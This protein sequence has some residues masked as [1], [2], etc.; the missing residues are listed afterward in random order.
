MERRRDFDAVAATWDENPVRVQRAH[1]LAEAMRRLVPLRPDM[2][3]MDYGCGTGLVALALQPYVGV[4]VAADNA[5]GMLAELTGKLQAAGLS[6]VAAQQV[7][8]EREAWTGEPFDVIVS[9]MALHHIRAAALVVKR[10]AG[11]LRPGGW[12]AIADLAG[13]SDSFHP[14]PTGVFHHGFSAETMGEMFAAAGLT[15]VQ[16]VEGATMSRETGDFVVL[17]TVGRR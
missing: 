12:L 8:L 11:A 6:N 1:D 14:D 3:L 13:G 2:R 10:L 7:D 4:V 17:L 9:S 15:E 16:T 5:P